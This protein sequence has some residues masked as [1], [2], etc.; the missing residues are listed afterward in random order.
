MVRLAGLEPATHGLGIHCSIR[1]ELQ[2]HPVTDSIMPA[3]SLA[4]T[5]NLSM[6]FTTHTQKAGQKFKN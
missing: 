5:G 4:E 1:T 2:A 3:L 6:C